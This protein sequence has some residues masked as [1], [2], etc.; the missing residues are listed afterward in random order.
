MDVGRRAAGEST[1]MPLFVTL[2][3]ILFALFFIVSGAFTLAD[4]PSAGREISAHVMIPSLAQPYMTQIENAVSIST[5]DLMAIV[6]GTIA[7]VCGLM[8]A[9]NLGT[10]FFALLL[11]LGIIIATFY[12]DDFWTTSGREMTDNLTHALKN[13]ALIGA[14]LMLFGYGAGGKMEEQP[15]HER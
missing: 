6:S 7:V 8:I 9:F 1:L 5:P 12:M 11:I 2:G 10:R 14:L 13:L 4:I 3:R 15:F